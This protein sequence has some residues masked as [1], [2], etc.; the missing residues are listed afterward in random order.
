MPMYRIGCSS[1]GAEHDIFRSLSQ[2]NDLPNCCGE[3]MTRRVCAPAVL[4]DIN[5]YRSQATGEM[6][7]GRRQHREHLKNNGLIEVGNEVINTS[8]PKQN[9]GNLKADIAEACHKVLG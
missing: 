6:I 3:P 7:M 9:L 1:C 4:A 8:K 5:P 2:Y